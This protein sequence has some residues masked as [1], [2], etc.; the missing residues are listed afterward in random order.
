[1]KREELMALPY[2][3]RIDA[4][5]QCYED[6]QLPTAT[7]YV[8]QYLREFRP[9]IPPV[10]DIDI[11]ESSEGIADLMRGICTIDTDDVSEIMTLMGY[12]L[13]FASRHS[14]AWAMKWIKEMEEYHKEE[15]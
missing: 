7:I 15:V 6:F 13:A 8:L 9:A 3:E 10:P 4:L 14:P 1:M 2:E 12:E 5:M 11:D